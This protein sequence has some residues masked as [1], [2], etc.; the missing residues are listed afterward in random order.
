VLHVA[1]TPRQNEVEVCGHDGDAGHW[2]FNQE[3][4]ISPGICHK[5]TTGIGKF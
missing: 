1:G 5:E 4:V 2:A 3:P